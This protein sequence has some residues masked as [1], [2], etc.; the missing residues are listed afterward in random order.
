M[1]IDSLG[2]HFKLQSDDHKASLAPMKQ[3][4]VPHSG[5]SALPQTPHPP[6]TP[7]M[8]AFASCASNT[9][10]GLPAVHQEK[11]SNTPV[12]SLRSGRAQAHIHARTHARTH[13]RARTHTHARTYTY[14]YTRLA[15]M[16]YKHRQKAGVLRGGQKKVGNRQASVPEQP[17]LSKASLSPARRL[18]HQGATRT[19]GRP[20]IRVTRA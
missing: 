9:A 20:G 19:M 6:M 2:E 8:A 13:A 12:Q 17:L 3:I 1:V 15:S 14:T 7:V 18:D 10:T 16:P 5:R 11:I 4:F